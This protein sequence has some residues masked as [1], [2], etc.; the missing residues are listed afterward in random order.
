MVMISAPFFKGFRKYLYI[1]SHLGMYIYIY[2]HIMYV[3]NS[4]YRSTHVYVE[5]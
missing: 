1:F 3:C 5:R 2:I 4:A